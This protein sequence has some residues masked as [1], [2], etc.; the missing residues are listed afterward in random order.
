M[1]RTRNEYIRV[2]ARSVPPTTGRD[3]IPARRSYKMVFVPDEDQPR[4]L[5]DTTTVT[6]NVLLVPLYT[7]KKKNDFRSTPV[8]T[9][10]D[11]DFRSARISRFHVRKRRLFT[12]IPGPRTSLSS[13][14]RVFPNSHSIQK[15]PADSG[16]RRRLGHI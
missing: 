2:C 13:V 16:L 9:L 8:V 5:L 4:K 15:A 1:F 11:I 12:T 3:E 7:Y 14:P 6:A 10:V